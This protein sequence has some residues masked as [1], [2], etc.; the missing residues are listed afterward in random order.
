LADIAGRVLKSYNGYYYAAIDASDA[1]KYFSGADL[2]GLSVQG[3]VLVTCK[4]K[5]RMKKQRFSL[6][7][8]DMV[9]VEPEGV[10]CEKLQDGSERLEL[11]GMI[12]G[13]LPRKNICRRPVIANLDLLVLTQAA[14]SPDFSFL[15]M[16]KLLV[17]AEA[18][19]L[20][21]IIA[22][23][24]CDLAPQ[25][26]V[27]EICRV[28]GAAGYEVLPLVSPAGNG[29]APLKKRL[30]GKICALGGPSG[31][32]KS[33]LLNALLPGIE[34]RT[35]AVSK[36]IGRGRHT[37]RFAELIPFEGGYLADTPGFGN[38][39]MEGVSTDKL[40]RCF[41]EFLQYEGACRFSPCSHMHEPV[42]GVRSAVA[43]HAIDARRYASY[44]E[45]YCELKELEEQNYK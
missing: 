42:C 39:Y 1:A 17:M 9:S 26:L 6:C 27:S 8:G 5:G 31:V 34:R 22:L 20:P 2:R 24:K 35:G 14:A 45:I 4:I 12:S 19:Q 33:T 16:D 28:Y 11:Q 15:I 44:T 7:T 25:S 23:T 13:V 41:P 37:T 38:V 40:A 43:S 3:S 32:G 30:S 36:K 18:Q 10:L 29:L 21:A